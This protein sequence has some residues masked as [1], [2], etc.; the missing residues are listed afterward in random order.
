MEA[1]ALEFLLNALR[2]KE[3]FS[4]FLFEGRTGVS[5]STIGKQVEYL[6]AQDLLSQTG[7]QIQATEKG[8]ELLN[9]VLEEFL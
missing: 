4:I 7:A 3:G 2:L 1:R 5:F 6:I 8:Y 9:S